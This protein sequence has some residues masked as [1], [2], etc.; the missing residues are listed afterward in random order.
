MS[1]KV[2]GEAQRGQDKG[3]HLVPTVPCAGEVNEQVKCLQ[4]QHENPSPVPKHPHTLPSTHTSITREAEAGGFP[5]LTT[6]ALDLWPLQARAHM[7]RHPWD[8][9][10]HVGTWRHDTHSQ[11]NTPSLCSSPS[12]FLHSEA[13]LGKVYSYEEDGFPGGSSKA[14]LQWGWGRFPQRAL[15]GKV[16]WP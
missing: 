11:R 4:K 1:R 3:I 12:Q 13:L 15:K 14:R 10:R 6:Q 7:H 8:A 16:S 2:R 9:W 5:E